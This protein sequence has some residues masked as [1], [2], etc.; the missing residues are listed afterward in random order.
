MEPPNPKDAEKNGDNERK[1]DGD[2]AP[3][4][5]GSTWGMSGESVVKETQPPAD[6]ACHDDEGHGQ[7]SRDEQQYGQSD[8]HGGRLAQA[9]REGK[10]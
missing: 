1:E 8:K 7:Y 3:E 2:A 6:Q 5:H 10:R 9:A 4:G